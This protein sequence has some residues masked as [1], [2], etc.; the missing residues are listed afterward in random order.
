MPDVQEQ[1]KNYFN[2]VLKCFQQKVN[3]YRTL[4][5]NDIAEQLGVP[6]EPLVYRSL[7]LLASQ[8]IISKDGKGAYRLVQEIF[9]C[10]CGCDATIQKKRYPNTGFTINCTREGC[11]AIVKRSRADDAIESWNAMSYASKCG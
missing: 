3:R 4:T 2:D 1:S 6:G 8:N 5:P 9:S 7:K 10:A 11:P